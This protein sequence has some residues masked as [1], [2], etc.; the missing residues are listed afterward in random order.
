[1]LDVLVA[2]AGP[3]GCVAA[4]VL[5]RAGARVLVVDRACFP[6]HKLCGDTLNPGALAILRRLGLPIAEA[7]LPISGMVV[8]GPGGVRVTARYPGAIRGRAIVRRRLD[9][10]LVESAASAGA[11]IEE[12]VLVRAPLMDG[13][14]P[15]VVGLRVKAGGNG[16][17]RELR[18][19]LVIAADG[20]ESRVARAIALSCHPRRP[21]R[22]AVGAYFEHG[23]GLSDCGEMHVRETRYI[24]VAPLAPGLSN[25]CIVTAQ[26]QALAHPA[27]LLLHVLR[28]EPEL[29]ARFASARMVER[30]VMLGPLAVECAAP[31]CAGLLLA[32]DAAGFV[33]P[34]TG[35]GLRF[36]MRGAELAAAEALRALERGGEVSPVRLAAARRRE[37]A[38]KWR[39]NRALRRLTGSARAIRAAQLASR[40][41][42]WPVS[43]IIY[44]AGDLSAA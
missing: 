17:E 1:M 8:T 32:G 40:L 22:W 39:F 35:D 38:G 34:M 4:I 11:Q 33:D 23:G 27:A 37:F 10:A 36:A 18:A 15:G 12:G 41:S 43:R 19:R 6:R 5:A 44:S 24:G 7:G 9:H 42:G 29:A 21:R 16:G 14:R 28:T 13:R 3:A 26:R 30:P 31:G 2:G 20:R 25:V